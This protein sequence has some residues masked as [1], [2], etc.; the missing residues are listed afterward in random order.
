MGS[1]DGHGELALSDDNRNKTEADHDTHL[2][3]PPANTDD[4]QSPAEK[5]L[6]RFYATILALA[7]TG[8]LA[9][10]EA[11]IKST[12]LPTIIEALGGADLFIWVVNVYF[13]TMHATSHGFIL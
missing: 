3:S 12:A 2:P 4:K 8:L 5:K 10:L 9:A 7:F 13:L 6:L 11:T 1:T